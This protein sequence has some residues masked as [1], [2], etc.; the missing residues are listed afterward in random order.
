MHPRLG[1]LPSPVLDRNDGNPHLY[2]KPRVI[3]DPAPARPELRVARMSDRRRALSILRTADLQPLFQSIGR[4][5][6][7]S[8]PD[9]KYPV[10]LA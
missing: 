8:V 10:H 6:G 9:I 2:A 4:P 5:C 1:R 3:R 7:V